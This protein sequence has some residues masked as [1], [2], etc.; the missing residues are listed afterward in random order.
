MKKFVNWNYLEKFEGTF[1][2]GEF[3]NPFFMNPNLP[4]PI[5]ALVFMSLV[6]TFGWSFF[7]SSHVPFTSWIQERTYFASDLSSLLLLG[8]RSS[9]L[10][11]FSVWDISRDTSDF[12]RYFSP[13]VEVGLDR[14]SEYLW[15]CDCDIYYSLIISKFFII[16]L[17]F[18][19]RSGTGRLKC[20]LRHI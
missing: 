12:V 16:Q 11:A 3:L 6:I 10:T 20:I 8:S 17:S 13:M 5:P 1:P 9:F 18:L 4:L 7:S 19:Q 14:N 2:S 15:M